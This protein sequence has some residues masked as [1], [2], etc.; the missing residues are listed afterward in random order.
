MRLGYLY[1]ETKSLSFDLTLNT[2]QFEYQ[3]GR[4]N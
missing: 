1:L 3:Y 4:E 2:Q